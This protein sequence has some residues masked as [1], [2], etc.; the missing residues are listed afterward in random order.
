[1]RTLTLNLLAALILVPLPM[2]AGAGPA[3]GLRERVMALQTGQVEP[4]ACCKLCR[5]GKA[6]GDSCISRDKVCHKAPG[7]ACDG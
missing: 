1:M 5:K 2:Q 4:A 7:C 3:L 6:C